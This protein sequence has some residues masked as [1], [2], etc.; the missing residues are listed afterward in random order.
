[1]YLVKLYKDHADDKGIVIHSPY[2]SDIKLS[3]G[4]I[5]YVLGSIHDFDFAVNI[6]NPSWTRIEPLKT[7]ITVTD[8]LKNKIIYEGRALQPRAKMNANGSFSKQITC[9][10]LLAYLVDST[11]RH[12]EIHDTTISDF[13]Q[14]IIDNHNRQVEPH[15][16][17]RLGRVTVTNTTD[18]VYRYLGYDNTY[19]T[20]KEKLVDRLGGYIQLRRD[21]GLLYLDYL[22]EVG[23]YVES[24]PIKLAHNMQSVD[25]E[26]DPTEVI[27]RLVPL[28][29]SLD[30][31]DDEAT[32][33]SQARLTIESVNNGIDYLDDLDL[34]AEF[35]IVEKPI[36]WNDVTTPQ[37]LLTNGRNYLRDQKTAIARINV[38]STNSYLLG[39]DIASF[40][41]G[42]YHDLINQVVGLNERV[43]IIE[44]KIDINQPQKSSL[45]IG[46]KFRTLSQY[47]L[48]SN[49]QARLVVELQSKVD[50][51]GRSIATIRGEV[52][53]VETNLGNLQQVIDNAD[54]E[55]LPDAISALEQAISNLNDALDGI[56]IYGLATHIVDGLMASTDKVKLDALKV[57]GD[58]TEL[59]AG[60]LSAPDKEKLNRLTVTQSIDL[61]QLYQ[62]V[63]DLKNT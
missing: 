54:I 14:I 13:L 22:E 35:G 10:S 7:I 61:D 8:V 44:K 43:Q 1:M 6:K 27:T 34:Q 62:D 12:A 51:Q 41:I 16:Q 63:Q 37:R 23:D 57:Y 33:A 31:E 20:I 15:K 59:M 17:V 19:D 9:E 58:A 3:S 55:G 42:N 26:V 50:G 38:N 40:E 49:K 21:N 46:D 18:N 52:T 36:T 24:T 28:G 56:P 4:Q 30:S 60:L 2:V 45:K 29:E 53:N 5:N 47:Q 39:K 11:Q 48:A 32:D 25:Y